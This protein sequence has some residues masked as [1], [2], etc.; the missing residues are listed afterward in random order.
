MVLMSFIVIGNLQ[1]SRLNVLDEMFL[2]RFFFKYFFIRKFIK[3]I[4][5]YY[6][7]KIIF[8]INIL[9]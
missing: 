6:L 5:Y 2:L 7:K 1:G 8:D 3:I 9:K 4:F